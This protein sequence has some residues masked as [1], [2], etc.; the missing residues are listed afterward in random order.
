[1]LKV[2][3]FVL[4]SYNRAHYEKLD[5]AI[6]AFLSENPI[7]VIDI[8]YSSAIAADTGST[9]FTHSALLLYKTKD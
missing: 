7:E 4:N 5:D 2:K 1:M 8:R 3:T 9:Y 6:N